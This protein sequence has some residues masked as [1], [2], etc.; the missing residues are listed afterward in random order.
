MFKIPYEIIKKFKKLRK[1]G[2]SAARNVSRQNKAKIFNPK[3]L[4][5]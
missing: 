1:Y 3:I 5:Q 4:T 2:F